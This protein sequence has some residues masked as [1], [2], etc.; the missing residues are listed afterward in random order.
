VIDCLEADL[1]NLQHAE[2]IV[3]LLD[4]YARD[5]MGGGQP[6][7]RFARENLVPALRARPSALV[8]L[9]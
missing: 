3:M 9:A 8:I 7:S 2:A 6:L 5:P 4:A 1:D